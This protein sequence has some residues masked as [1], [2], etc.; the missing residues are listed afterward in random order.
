MKFKDLYP[1]LLGGRWKETAGRMEVMNP[2]NGQVVTNVCQAGPEDVEEALA[3]AE[4][5][6]PA[7]ASLASYK[8]AGILQKISDKIAARRD[9]LARIITSENGKPI[10]E[11]RGEAERASLTFRM[12]SEEAVRTGGEYI[13]L[14]RNIA[15]EG[16]W[17]ITRRFPA[18][19][20]LG[21]TPFNFPLNLVAHKIAPAIAAGNPIMLKPAS[22][23][24]VS[25]LVLGEIAM[26]SGLPEG[27]LSVLPASSKVIGAAITDARIKVLSFT[28]SATVG[29]QLK[30]LAFDKKVI[31]ELGGNAG[32]LLDEDCDLEY[33]VDRCVSGAFSYAGQVCISVQRIYAHRKIYDEF[34]KLFVPKVKKLK[35]GDPMDET[36]Q[37]GPMI[38]EDNLARVT[39][40]VSE[41]VGAGAKLTAGGQRSGRFFYEPSVIVDATPEMKL[42]CMEV[43]A[44]VVTVAPVESFAGGLKAINGSVYGLQSGVFTGNLRHAFEAFERIEA[45]GVIINDVP[46]Y[47]VDHMPYGGV[48]QSGAGREGIKY[49]IEEMTE[50]R[51]MAIKLV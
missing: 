49:A 41:A 48:K 33:A 11:A 43:F 34:L 35:M 39:S 40:W 28:G 45:G 44:P 21:I 26:E 31:L 2:Y 16:R 6:R 3:L 27:G 19:P 25:A 18:G 10:A 38:D 20:V 17:G 47:R 37:I 30:K 12:A 8:K 9:E 32:V 4:K 46:T 15:S 14:D 1:L 7:L 42:S 22:K 13:P 29:W 36:V 50:L 23:T 5:A 24:P 51:L